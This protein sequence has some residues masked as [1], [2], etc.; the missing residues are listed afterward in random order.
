MYACNVTRAPWLSSVCSWDEVETTPLQAGGR[1]P[2]MR[3]GGGGHGC[4][5]GIFCRRADRRGLACARVDRYTS[6]RREE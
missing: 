5:A 6:K 2:A 1:D 3:I 4:L